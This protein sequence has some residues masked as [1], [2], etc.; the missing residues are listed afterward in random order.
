[1]R[2][3]ELQV[4]A[5]PPFSPQA[6]ADTPP[7]QPAPAPPAAAEANPW[8]D[9]WTDQN[10]GR[11]IIWT[12][13]TLARG[14]GDPALE[15]DKFTVELAAPPLAACMRALPFERVTQAVGTPSGAKW[16]AVGLVVILALAVGIPL[17]IALRRRAARK[18]EARTAEAVTAPPEEDPE[19][20]PNGAWRARA[21]TV[22][23]GILGE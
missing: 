18:A 22:G 17:L 14:I 4:N 3:V 13:H 15:A 5:P 23:S 11:V 7:A 1:M 6:A 12:R 21:R 8:R 20:S 9:Y 2:E 19:P 10:A 16:A